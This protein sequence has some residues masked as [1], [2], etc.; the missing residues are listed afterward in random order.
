M[1][2]RTLAPILLLIV[3]C[4]TKTPDPPPDD[5]Y[6][7]AKQVAG[8]CR[9]VEPRQH[10]VVLG[11]T[12]DNALRAKIAGQNL[13]LPQCWYEERPDQLVLMAGEICEGYD[14]VH[15][16]KVNGEWQLTQVVRQDLVMC[17]ERK[18]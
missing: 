1:C 3:G 12:L 8:C 5:G 17:H 16:Q 9:M 13:E 4:A 7:R 18:R 10:D 15:F 2:S 14:E 6:I 11:P